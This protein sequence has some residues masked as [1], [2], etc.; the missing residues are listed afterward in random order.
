MG[1]E[2]KDARSDNVLTGVWGSLKGWEGDSEMGDSLSSIN[3]MK[4]CNDLLS[5]GLENS[6]PALLILTLGGTPHH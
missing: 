6:D 1:G 3:I 4:E 2:T 5:S